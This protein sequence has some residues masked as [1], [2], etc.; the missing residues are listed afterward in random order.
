MTVDVLCTRHV[1]QHGLTLSWRCM[2][3]EWQGCQYVWSLKQVQRS[4]V[5]ACF[6][7]TQAHVEASAHAKYSYPL[8]G[9]GTTRHAFAQ[10]SSSSRGSI[11]LT[12][13]APSYSP[14]PDPPSTLLP[15]LLVCPQPLH[16]RAPS[17]RWKS[18]DDR[19][20][21]P[22]SSFLTGAL[23]RSCACPTSTW[24]P[25]LPRVRRSA[26]PLEASAHP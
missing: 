13:H 5:P 20:S 8:S 21:P 14:S 23:R 26:S 1:S 6:A 2:S 17:P 9:S 12:F 3:V 15:T 4:R 19:P 11:P 24:T 22:P 10:T 7:C 16:A 25:P 18:T